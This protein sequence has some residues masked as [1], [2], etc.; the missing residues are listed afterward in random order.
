MQ[1]ISCEHL[2]SRSAPNAERIKLAGVTLFGHFRVVGIDANGANKLPEDSR[3]T[4][5]DSIA[6]R[7]EVQSDA[8]QHV[9]NDV[10]D[11]NLALAKCRRP[12]ISASPSGEAKP[13]GEPVKPK[14]R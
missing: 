9:S 1:E 3:G 5:I 4:R 13:R 8:S 12:S 14:L 7:L 11:A 10:A 2:G 6:W